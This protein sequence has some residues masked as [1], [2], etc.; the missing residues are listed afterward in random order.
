MA[1]MAQNQDA[2]AL[3]ELAQILANYASQGEGGPV[4][5][6]QVVQRGVAIAK[7]SGDACEDGMLLRSGFCKRFSGGKR[8]R[9]MK[10][11]ACTRKLSKTLAALLITLEITGTSAMIYAL[12]P[13][14]ISGL[15]FAC[16]EAIKSTVSGLLAAITASVQ[17]RDI[18]IISKLWEIATNFYG[19]AG[20][21]SL[22]SIPFR[23]LIG[24]HYVTLCNAIENWLENEG[25]GAVAAAG[26]D[27]T[28]VDDSSSSGGARRRRTYKKR[29]GARRG[30]AR[31]SSCGM[32]GGRKRKTRRGRKSRGR[33][34]RGRKS[35]GR[36]SRVHKKRRG[37]KSKKH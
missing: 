5:A 12:A 30:G 22:V 4:S 24:S 15:V 28:A 1:S 32:S 11:G 35:R 27:A 14:E 8:R 33:K 29:G 23:R 10:G 21:I 6:E 25:V 19:K 3:G 9:K 20:G 31:G 16:Y 37:R 36:K 13:A 17:L 2:Q 26:V 34:S 7:E 18:N